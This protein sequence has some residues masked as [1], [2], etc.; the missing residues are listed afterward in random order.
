[1]STIRCPDCGK[2]HLAP[3]CSRAANFGKDRAHSWPNDRQRFTHDD[4]GSKFLGHYFG[5][6]VYLANS[7]GD[8]FGGSVLA[9]YGNEPY[10]YASC[11]CQ[12][13]VDTLKGNGN[14]GGSEQN[15]KY[16]TMPYQDY[17]FSERCIPSTK[18]MI[19]ALTIHG[20]VR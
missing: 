16:W 20:T 18:A 6:D 2:T 17:V 3:A 5:H 19:I 13:F 7:P 1:M 10:E 12:I 8:I 11:A 14:I 15:G 9:R 4:P